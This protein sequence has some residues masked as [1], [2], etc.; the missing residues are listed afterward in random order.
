MFQELEI[1]ITFPDPIICKQ[2][3][4]SEMLFL[5]NTAKKRQCRPE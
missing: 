5:E 2:R 1:A 3:Y 4:N